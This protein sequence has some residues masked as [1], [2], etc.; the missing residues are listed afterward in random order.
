[1][2]TV[3]FLFLLY[4]QLP[5]SFKSCLAR[6]FL[7]AGQNIT[8][9]TSVL[10]SAG[11][12]FV[13]G[14]FSPAGNPTQTYLGIW[15]N[16]SQSFSSEQPPTV[17][18]VANRD[19]PILNSHVGVFQ[20]ADDGNIVVK[21]KD[22]SSSKTYYYW[23]SELEGSSS[24]NRTVKLM[25]SGNL[26]LFHNN[27]N[28]WQSFQHPTD[29]FLPG[30]KMD[31]N[32]ELTSWRGDSDPG[33]GNFTFK[34]KSETAEDNPPYIILNNNELYWERPESSEQNRLESRFTV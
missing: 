6:D 16:Q 19:K 33:T 30:M 18:W 26:V 27:Q 8:G 13:L 11:Q 7:N 17:V 15:Y 14:F 12:R 2:R 4:L 23:S 1:M 28:I 24:R 21:V 3:T 31:T 9:T 5:C 29:T 25:D 34:I 32:M 22:G 20:I 10:V